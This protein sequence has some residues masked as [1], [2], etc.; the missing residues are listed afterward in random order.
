MYMKH[1]MNID[2]HDYYYLIYFKDGFID[3]F[4]SDYFAHFSHVVHQRSLTY[5]VCSPNEGLC[6]CVF[7][8]QLFSF[9]V[10]T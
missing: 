1:I 6:V 10:L 9:L 2:G 4:L 3:G 7:N 8:F 5:N